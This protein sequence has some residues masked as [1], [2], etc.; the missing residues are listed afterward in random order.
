MR[1]LSKHEQLDYA[2]TAI[3]YALGRNVDRKILAKAFARKGLGKPQDYLGRGQEQAP[4]ANNPASPDPF[5][6]PDM[7]DAKTAR[8]RARREAV[9]REFTRDEG[10]EGAR[11]VKSSWLD[12]ADELTREAERLGFYGASREDLGVK[13]WIPDTHVGYHDERAWKLVLKVARDT[14]P[15]AV[16]HLG[17]LADFFTVSDHDRSPERALSLKEELETHNA[18]LDDIDSIGG[19]R[20][21]YI[22]NHDVRLSKYLSKKAPELWGLVNVK[23]QWNLKKRGWSWTEYGSYEVVDGIATSHHFGYCGATA[24]RK[25]S[26]R[27]TISSING[28][29]HRMGIIVEGTIDGKTKVSASF[30]WLGDKNKLAFHYAADI[31]KTRDWTLGFGLGWR[32]SDGTLHIQPVP[33][34]N[35]SCVVGGKVYSV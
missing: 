8:L 20:R 30:G 9:Q 27:T 4:L 33:I 16:E 17:D 10:L 13:L 15:Y 19:D 26:D 5:E 34:Q 35:Y 1:L 6:L 7:V 25:N 23:E 24:L 31:Q 12:A 18:F 29:T 2:I 11:A 14:Q 22:G 21:L 3:G 32:Q 28:H